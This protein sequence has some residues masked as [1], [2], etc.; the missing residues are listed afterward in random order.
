MRYF[1]KKTNQS[2]ISKAF[3]YGFTAFVF[4][5]LFTS[6]VLLIGIF[7]PRPDF[8]FVE[9]TQNNIESLEQ[10]SQFSKLFLAPWYRWDTGHYIE[11]ADYGYDFDP[12][13][14]VW[15]PLY[16]FLIKVTSFIF[17]PTLLAALIVSNLFFIIGLALF[18]LLTKEMFSEEL[19]KESIFY[20]LFFPTSFYFVA[21]FTESIFLTFSIAVFLF[22]R[23]KK[24]LLAG[25]FC[26]LATL[27]RVQGLFLIIPVLFELALTYKKERDLKAFLMNSI[28]SVYAPFAYGLFSLY[29]FFGLRNP[30]PWHT[31]SENWG[32]HFGFPW[33]GIVGT[34]QLLFGK[35]VEYDVT[36]HLVKVVNLVITFLAIF[37]L[38]KLRKKIPVSMSIYSWVMLLVAIGKI[39][40]NNVLVSV[41]RYVLIIFPLFW[42]LALL[43]KQRYQKILYF[44][45]GIILQIILLVSFY[46]WFWV[47]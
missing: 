16:P 1:I 24:W 33:E 43:I 30:W 38:Y 23:R 29:V 41:T 18:F 32:L 9:I 4:L 35:Q 12:V 37:L 19:S 27:T 3:F 22:I 5:R 14:S 25:I 10:R 17:K 8:T 36:P 40:E 2:I 28:P 21:G 45:T 34:V 39:D 20:L 44:V 46:W 7:F 11:V 31:L 13:N 42:G 15:P 6:I 26:F 47:A